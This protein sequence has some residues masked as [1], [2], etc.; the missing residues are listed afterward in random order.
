MFVDEAVIHVKAG[1]GGDGAVAFRREKFVPKGGPEGGD[2]GD[3]GSVIFRAD[4]NKNTLFDFS[5]RH[6][7][8]AEN[9]QQGMGK[10][11]AGKSG[12]DLLILV[13]P[14]TLIFDD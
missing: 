14:G 12:E 7:W 2:G 3:G 9:G 13:P 8:R 6:H 1:K 4:P 11:M 5:G 10:K